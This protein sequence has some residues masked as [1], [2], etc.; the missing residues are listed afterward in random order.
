MTNE[1]QTHGSSSRHTDKLV[2]RFDRFLRRSG[3]ALADRFGEETA[4]V[5]RGEM[6][7]EYRRLIP[8]VPYIG[9]RRNIYS[10]NL[11]QAPW[12][13]AAYRVVIR[14]GGGLEETG[15]LLHRMVRAEAERVPQ[16]ARSVMR[17]Y[18][19][20]PLRQRT[21]ARAARRSQARRYPGDWVFE[22]IEGDGETFD[23][24]I[25]MTECGVVK[26]LHAQGA[27]ELV[28]YGCDLDYVMFEALGVGLQRTKT[29]AWGC[30]RCDFRL[31][32]HG[33]TSA[34]WPPEFVERTCGEPAEAGGSSR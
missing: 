34:P 30:D 19:F 6:L 7:D 11:A 5:M 24:G 27:D 17:W 28:P 10:T 2:A 22:R 31:S 4:A 20:S 33:T 18:L 32:K 12:A 21:V 14:H 16:L 13:L 1:A 23:F 15:Q 26:Y 25:D 3:G 9:G 29:L 8:E